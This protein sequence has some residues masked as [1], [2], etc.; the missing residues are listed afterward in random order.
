MTFPFVPKKGAKCPG[1]HGTK[2]THQVRPLPGYDPQLEHWVCD[3]CQI[4]WYQRP[5]QVNT[6]VGGTLEAARAAYVPRSK[7]QEP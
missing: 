7:K 5:S 3:H 1:C 4:G 2:E 6:R